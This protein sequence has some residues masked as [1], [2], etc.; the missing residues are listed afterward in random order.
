MFQIV[1]HVQ[2]LLLVI[3]AHW[4]FIIRLQLMPIQR[5]NVWL[6]EEQEQF[7]IVYNVQVP[8]LVMCVKQDIITQYQI[9]QMFAVNVVVLLQ[10]VLHVIFQQVLQL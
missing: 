10:I 5:D 3:N 4:D 1:L 8:Q 7:K 2:M 6:V 9:M